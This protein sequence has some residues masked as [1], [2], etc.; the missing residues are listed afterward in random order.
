MAEVAATAP[1]REGSA[2]SQPAPIQLPH[3]PDR[4]PA[5][6]AAVAATIPDVFRL[7]TA[8]PRRSDVPPWSLETLS[9]CFVELSGL[10]A[11]SRLTLALGLVREAQQC[12]E[13][14]VWVTDRAS[15]FFPPDAAANGVDLDT[16]PVVFA[17]HAVAAG[18]SAERLARSG[19]VSV[20]IL[21]LVGMG[22]GHRRSPG[23]E[24]TLP[25][26][27]QSRLSGLAREHATAI[28]CLT[29]KPADRPSLGSLVAVRCEARRET[30]A[31]R[32]R[33]VC[34][35]AALKDKRGLTSFE[36]WLHTEIHRGPAGLC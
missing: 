11:T 17:P 29:T 13:P 30:G 5:R 28:V 31:A 7:P 32:D 25:D 1:A 14:A 15:T 26:A 9:G 23:R 22:S 18:K 4:S 34:R 35:A 2:P 36:N 33:F 19:A 8:P 24:V 27:V 12:G 10:G 3:P 21:D 20:L 16:L 6:A